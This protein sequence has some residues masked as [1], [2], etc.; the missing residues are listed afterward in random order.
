MSD[1]LTGVFVMVRG[2]G[3]VKGTK[4]RGSRGVVQFTQGPST[5]IG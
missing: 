1:N 3:G 2:V 5:T 4:I